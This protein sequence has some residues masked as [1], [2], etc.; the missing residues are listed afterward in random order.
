[1]FDLASL[2]TPKETHSSFGSYLILGW[3]PKIV[4]LRRQTQSVPILKR[5]VLL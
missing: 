1:M 3:L 4:C 2:V 5:E